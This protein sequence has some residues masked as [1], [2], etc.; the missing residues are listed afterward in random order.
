MSH[1]YETRGFR[2]FLAGGP[3][4]KRGCPPIKA[5]PVK[6]PPFR[7]QLWAA[8]RRRCPYCVFPLTSWRKG[9]KDHVHPKSRG[10]SLR[11]FNQVLAHEDCNRRKADRLPHPCETL[12]C[13]ITHEIRRAMRGL[14]KKP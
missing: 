11:G 5:R 12:F 2:R 3:V 1:R 8:Q 7:A 4:P 9:T 10:G 13:Q 6:P 14:E